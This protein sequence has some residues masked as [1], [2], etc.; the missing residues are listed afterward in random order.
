MGGVRGFDSAGFRLLMVTGHEVVLATAVFK[1]F[2]MI[3]YAAISPAGAFIMNSR[4]NTVT[5]GSTAPH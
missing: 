5:S 3:L 2:L 4:H 1:G